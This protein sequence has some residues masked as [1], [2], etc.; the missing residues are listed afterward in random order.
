MEKY[1]TE[2][3][4]KSA[5]YTS[6]AV[7]LKKAIERNRRRAIL[8]GLLYL[9]STVLLLVGAALPLLADNRVS[10]GLYGN[11]AFWLAF[12]QSEATADGTL[13]M[14]TAVIYALILIGVVVNVFRSLCRLNWLF[15]KRGSK[16]YGF[17]RN[18]YAAD[19][20]GKIFSGSYSLLVIGYFLMAILAGRALTNTIT[21]VVVFGGLVVHFVVGFLSSKAT[22]FNMEDDELTIQKRLV[23]RIAPLVRNGLQVL[24]AF[25]MMFF[26]IK[27]SSIHNAIVPLFEQNA[28]AN[29]VTNNVMQWLSIV[30]QVLLV[31]CIVVFTKH[32]LGIAEYN[33]NGSQGDWMKVSRVFAFF[34]VLMAAVVILCRFMF[35]EI[36]FALNEAGTTWI[37]STPK[38]WLGGSLDA[39]NVHTLGSWWLWIVGGLAFVMFIVE[40]I[41]RNFPR[42]PKKLQETD[43]PAVEPVANPYSPFYGGFDVPVNY[44]S[45]AA[46]QS[47]EAPVEE[48]VLEEMMEEEPVEEEY[49]EDYE[50]EEEEEEEIENVEV[51]C[52]ACGKLLYVSDSAPYHRC[53]SCGAVFQ[54]RK[55]TTQVN[56]D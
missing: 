33:I 43:E 53:P 9:V 11:R 10:A 15:K 49:E 22:Y 50:E 52:P 56:F 18:I 1:K 41:M 42:I 40:I 31:L 6:K 24:F 45:G 51:N 20:M 8:V 48:P 25:V 16:M 36:H 39:I 29:Y 7:V 32:A 17:N 34:T 47:A 2:K 28:I 4:R 23:G 54:V 35:G 3:H 21:L 38:D 14:I 13:R 27:G 37:V 5:V 26:V 46:Q 44:T 30:V 19:D 55:V 12:T